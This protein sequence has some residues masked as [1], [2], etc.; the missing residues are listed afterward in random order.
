MSPRVSTSVA[1]DGITADQVRIARREGGGPATTWLHIVHGQV[2]IALGGPG[3]D[4]AAEAAALRQLAKL[5][6]WIAS[7]LEHRAALSAEPARYCPEGCGCRYGT[8][9]ADARECGCDGPCTEGGTEWYA[10]G[11]DGAQ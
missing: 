1:I 7:E 3:A 8:E 10:T 2:W 5:A 6:T 4:L 9:D 11:Q